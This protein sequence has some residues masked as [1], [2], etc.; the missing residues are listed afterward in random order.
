ML[1]SVSAFFLALALC[2]SAFA[3]DTFT[4]KG[5]TAKTLLSV[6]LRNGVQNL[7]TV[8]SLNIGV[9]TVRCSSGMTIAGPM[10]S[11][12]VCS[13]IDTTTNEDIVFKGLDAKSLFQL[14]EKVGI[15][16]TNVPD[17]SW[18]EATSIRCSK[19]V[20]PNAKVTCVVAE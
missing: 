2:S 3:A 14:L 9:K 6:L 11:Q 10:A 5:T 16:A 17:A 15:K 12:R 8:G 7:G 18:I 13:M 1:K 20:V 19:P 4:V